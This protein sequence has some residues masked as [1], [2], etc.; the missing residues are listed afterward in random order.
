MRFSRLLPITLL[1]VLAPAP[2][3][4]GAVGTS[5][6]ATGLHISTGASTAPDARTWVSDHNAGFCRIVAPPPAGPGHIEHPDFDPN[7]PNSPTDTPTCLGGLLAGAAPG[8]D[9]SSAP[10]FFDPTPASPTP[11]EGKGFWP[12][13]PRPGPGGS[14]PA[15]PPPPRRFPTAAGG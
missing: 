4:S 11:G 10:A 14:N 15:R 8:P 5:L 13:G 2:S 7:T 1:A 9:A 3:A 12:P 6:Y